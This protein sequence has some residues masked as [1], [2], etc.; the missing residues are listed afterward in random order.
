MGGDLASA[1]DALFSIPGAVL[2]G[3]G[4]AIL[5]IFLNAELYVGLAAAKVDSKIELLWVIVALTLG[6]VVGKALVFHL[7]RAGSER[8]RKDPADR[9]PP[10]T[11]ATARLRR[12]GDAML[13]LLDRPVL[14]GLVVFISSLLAVPPLAVVTVVAPLS[15]QKLSVFLSMVF[16]GRTIQF[17]ALG[18]VIDGVF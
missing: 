5:P 3:I 16:L 8:F 12:V 6:T 13:E 15:R 10:R 4:S 18:F 2:F 9:R 14:G 1:G 11:R 7:I 17:L